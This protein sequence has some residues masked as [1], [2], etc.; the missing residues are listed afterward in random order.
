MQNENEFSK[1]LE[2]L[3]TKAERDLFVE[4]I[5]QMENSLYK[6]KGLELS[7]EKKQMLSEVMNKA[8]ALKV[9]SLTLAIPPRRETVEAV[10]RW[11]KQN[12]GIDLL[13]EIEVDSELIAGAQV[14]FNGRFID[15]SL[16]KEME[17]FSK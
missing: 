6:G 7:E 3:R 17:S 1:R 9:V 16:K 10:W 8:K 4:E 5:E 2:L 15:A 14:A 13:I 12:L 11:L